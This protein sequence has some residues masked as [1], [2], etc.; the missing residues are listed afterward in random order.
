MKKF[1]ENNKGGIIAV[2]M[3]L[4]LAIA[5]FGLDWDQS[6]IVWKANA[7]NALMWIGFPMFG[8][9][10]LALFIAGGNGK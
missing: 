5:G 7:S 3:V 6:Q 10:V 9:S 8:L 4:G 2:G 1:I